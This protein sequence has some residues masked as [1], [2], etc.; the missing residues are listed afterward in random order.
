M[1]FFL[2]RV[3]FLEEVSLQPGRKDSLLGGRNRTAIA[4]HQENAGVL[5]GRVQLD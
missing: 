5:T 2:E 4:E 3:D 1:L